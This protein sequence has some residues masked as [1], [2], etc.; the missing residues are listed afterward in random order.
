MWL[1]CQMMSYIRFL[2]I[3]LNFLPKND[4]NFWEPTKD[5]VQKFF[6]HGFFQAQD[7]ALI[8][9]AKYTNNTTAEQNMNAKFL[10]F[11]LFCAI[12]K[13][14]T[15]I[16]KNVKFYALPFF[17]YKRKWILVFCIPLHEHLLLKLITFKWN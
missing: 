4:P 9:T 17:P 2:A 6:A 13:D 15:K 3:F 7:I 10:F 5:W 16:E 11:E 12:L 1:R 14:F 8:P